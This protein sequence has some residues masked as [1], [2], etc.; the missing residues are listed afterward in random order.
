MLDLLPIFVLY[1]KRYD[2]R[3]KSAVDTEQVLRTITQDDKRA[4]VCGRGH[5]TTADVGGLP[6]LVFRRFETGR[7]DVVSFASAAAIGCG[8]D[9]RTAY[10]IGSETAK[11]CCALGV[12]VVETP[13]FLPCACS[14]D[15]SRS[16]FF[17]ADPTLARTLGA[18]FI[19]GVQS[20][21]VGA[22]S[23]VVGEFGESEM[24]NLFLAVSGDGKTVCR[25][26]AMLFAGTVDMADKV[27]EAGY[28]GVCI[29]E[30]GTVKDRAA[31]LN[32][33]ID[34]SMPLGC[35]EKKNLKEAEE[36]GY[37]DRERLDA[38]ARKVVEL[39]DYTFDDHAYGLNGKEQRKKSAL[40]AAEC[41]VLLKNES[42]LPLLG[43]SITVMGQCAKAFFVSDEVGEETETESLV[44]A[45]GK[46]RRIKFVDGYRDEDDDG[47]IIEALE[48][49]FPDET[50]IVVLG[51]SCPDCGGNERAVAL[52]ESQVKLV[53]RL[54]DSGRNVVAVVVGGGRYDLKRI[55]SAKAV[56]YAPYLGCGGAEALKKIICGEA[57]PCGRLAED[58][59]TVEK[60]GT[61]KILYPFGYGESFCPFSYSQTKLGEL[62]GQPTATLT[63][64]NEGRYTAS[65]VI[66]IYGETSEKKRFLIAF[67]K[68]KLRA[69]ES[70]TLT[71]RLPKKLLEGV[72]E[73]LTGTSR[74]DIR[75]R[76][77]LESVDE[78]RETAFLSSAEK[79]CDASGT[80][81]IKKT[82][83]TGDCLESMG[84][85]LGGKLLA[86]KAKRAAKAIAGGNRARADRIFERMKKLPVG[87]LPSFTRGLVRFKSVKAAVIAASGKPIK[88][89]LTALGIGAREH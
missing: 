7:A 57:C 73:I 18:A 48:Q 65:D 41:A 62:D 67:E 70:R 43:D 75:E 79:L 86:K 72:S 4:L 9:E 19:D 89:F 14:A 21:G 45:F 74:E 80:G 28:G 40:L 42:I 2:I 77:A 17:S 37:I 87:A 36:S 32:G 13:S 44:E 78:V 55:S 39:I 63:V 58:F 20:T 35:G 50:V 15:G 81:A 22:M 69:G 76:V 85:T 3:R 52:P 88:A 8:F 12:H 64:R 71:V 31:A 61:E 53:E 66:Q 84:Q 25:P 10:E 59:V 51:E 29:S 11:Q 1:C 38:A 56:I 46:D 27:K 49:T 82:F 5:G 30:W 6:S 47:A 26:R 68:A 23:P 60:D 24:S 33:G 54:E 83:S 34:L 16:R